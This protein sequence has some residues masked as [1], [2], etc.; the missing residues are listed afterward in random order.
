MFKAK[1][2]T[3]AVTGVLSLAVTGAAALAAFQPGTATAIV[4]ATETG[5]TTNIHAEREKPK[6]DG[7]KE[8]LDRL[9]QNGTITQAQA[10]AI[11]KAFKEAGERKDKE[12]DRDREGAAFLKRLL[13]GMLHPATEYI[14]LPK[15]AVGGQLK[16][17]KSLGE[18]ADTRPGKSRDGLISYVVAAL[19]TQLDK[20][21]AEGKISKERADEAKSHL[22][23]RVTK[24]VDHKR[25]RKPAP[26]K[27][28]KSEKRDAKPKPS[29]TA[30]PTG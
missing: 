29:P 30:K 23:E 2:A 22:T 12:S 13:G 19:S 8:I 28:R 11:L 9:V 20:A 15:E 1:L 17:G 6:K 14:G 25:E 18:I 7:I 10:E 21:V 4:A 24:F 26:P 16:A 3:A 5:A 27:E